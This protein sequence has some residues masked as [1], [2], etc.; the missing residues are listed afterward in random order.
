EEVTYVA[1]QLAT[2]LGSFV[3]GQL[4][5]AFIVGVLSSLALYFLDLPFWLLIGITAGI[6]NMVPFVGPFVGGALAAI[7]ALFNGSVSQALWAIGLFTL[8]QQFDNHVVTP[9]VQR[10]RVNL[11]PLVIVLALVAGGALAGLLG[12]L[13][14][15]P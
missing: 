3:R 1:N 12:V 8:I 6:L 7:V 9:V 11:S 13:L 4:L 14:A 10:T 15:V 5:V 2:A